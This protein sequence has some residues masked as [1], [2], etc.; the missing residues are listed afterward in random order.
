MAS[1]IP[2]KKAMSDCASILNTVGHPYNTYDIWYLFDE[3]CRMSEMN[4]DD[5]NER[6]KIMEIFIHILSKTSSRDK[7]EVMYKRIKS[8]IQVIQRTPPWYNLRQISLSATQVPNLFASERQYGKMV[9]EK[10]G[11]LETRSG[12]RAACETASMSPFD[13][14]IRFEPVL[15]HCM[16]TLWSTSIEEVGCFVHANSDIRLVASPDGLMTSGSLVEFKCPITREI[17]GKIP[18]DYWQQMQIQMEVTGAEECQYVEAIFTSNMP[19]RYEPPCGPCYN[20]SGTIYL[21]NNDGIMEYS[22]HTP[23]GHEALEVIPWKLFAYH[24]VKVARDR[25][26]FNKQVRPR[27]D[28]FWEDVEIAKE[29]KFVLV[30]ARKRKNSDECAIVF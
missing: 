8:M 1:I 25:D 9:L 22:Y 12:S 5:I 24:K 20:I 21:Y 15:R 6:K 3:S 10:A 30:N 18:E 7:S 14:G 11:K 13:W 17:G 4:E 28:K 27:I 16:E 2:Y 19:E 23:L 29:G 26:W